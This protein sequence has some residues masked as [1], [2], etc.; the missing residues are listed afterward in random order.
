MRQVDAIKE[1]DPDTRIAVEIFPICPR[2]FLSSSDSNKASHHDE[3]DEEEF[4]LNE[5]FRLI[6]E[7]SSVFDVELDVIM[8]VYVSS[9]LAL[10]IFLLSLYETF[11]FSEH[12]D[13]LWETNP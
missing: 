10:L 13:S 5:E 4:S 12:Y 11:Q 1:M 9:S 3:D 2:F 6:K 7:D 8:V